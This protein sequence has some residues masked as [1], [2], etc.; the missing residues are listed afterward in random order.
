MISMLKKLT[1]DVVVGV[2]D[3]LCFS[4]RG[5]YILKELGPSVTV[6]VFGN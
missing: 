4:L 5:L 1:K 3:Q 2:L 6:L